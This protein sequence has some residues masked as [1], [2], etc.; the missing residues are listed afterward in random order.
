M[1]TEM[2]RSEPLAVTNP[3][4]APASRLSIDVHAERSTEYDWKQPVTEGLLPV[5][6]LV[7]CGDSEAIPDDLDMTAAL[8]ELFEVFTLQR[9]WLRRELALAW[10]HGKIVDPRQQRWA[11]R[12]LE[13]KRSFT[14]VKPDSDAKFAAWLQRYSAKDKRW[15]A[16]KKF[17]D[18][19]GD[20]AADF[21]PLSDKLD[22]KTFGSCASDLGVL[23][24][25]VTG[26]RDEEEED[27]LRAEGGAKVARARAAG[28]EVTDGV[29]KNVKVSPDLFS[30]LAYAIEHSR[31]F[32]VR[33]RICRNPTCERLF[34]MA[35][36]QKKWCSDA[37]KMEA[38]RQK[39]PT[40]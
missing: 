26:L 18:S 35:T 10:L 2:E 9:D 32:G 25:E 22:S 20:F 21:G 28:A 36:E 29:R 17:T 5:L 31:D 16:R 40:G 38:H 14:S 11:R 23:V 30:A 33:Y 12:V 7:P 37:C 15:R 27:E 39:K 1:P 6:R 24:R 13:M 34:V 4:K 3:K 8:K 19:W